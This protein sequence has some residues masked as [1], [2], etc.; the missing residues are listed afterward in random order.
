[1]F[2]CL[3][4]LGFFGFQGVGFQGFVLSPRTSRCAAQMH[5]LKVQRWPVLRDVFI[6]KVAPRSRASSRM[7]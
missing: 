2:Y 6:R 3:R 7:M 4:V 5:A 1:M